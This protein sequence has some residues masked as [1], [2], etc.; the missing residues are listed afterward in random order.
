MFKRIFCLLLVLALLFP[1]LVSCGQTEEEDTVKITQ[2][3]E[4]I[5]LT[6]YGILDNL[7]TSDPDEQAKILSVKKSIEDSINTKTQNSFKTTLVY[8][9]YSTDAYEAAIEDVY[10]QFVA[11]SVAKSYVTTYVKAYESFKSDAESYLSSAAL[12]E[13]E[14]LERAAK[15]EAEKVA[16]EEEKARLD[17]IERGEEAPPEPIHGAALDILYVNNYEQYIRFVNKD[18]LVALDDYLKLDYKKITDYIHPNIL[19]AAKIKNKIYGVPMNMDVGSASY[20]LFNKTVTHALGL[21]EAVSNVKTLA[22]CDSILSAV[23]AG[24]Q[25]YILREDYP[26]L[27]N[28]V[29]MRGSVGLT[30]YDFFQDTKGFP[31]SVPNSD[32]DYYSAENVIPTYTDEAAIAHFA[33]MASYREKGYFGGNEDAPYFFSVEQLTASEI[34]AIKETDEYIILETPYAYSNADNSNTLNGFFAVST[35]SKYANRCMEIISM[36]VLNSDLINLYYYGIEGETGTYILH[37]NGTVT[38]LN[39][40]W[41]MDLHRVGNT[42]LLYPRENQSLAYKQDAIYNRKNSKDS[43]FLSFSIEYTA[44]EAAQIA[45]FAALALPYYE[46]LCSGDVSYQKTLEELNAKLEEAG[47]STFI[48][49]TLAPAFQSVAKNLIA[50]AEAQKL[51]AEEAEKQKE[52]NDESG[53]KI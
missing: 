37:D 17:R 9:W 5:Y 35:K 3:R 39:D 18:Y 53:D 34:A 14:K 43:A 30:G 48:E 23:H 1:A 36:F 15:R 20:M 33:R 44:E 46:K 42:Y 19:N 49:T 25:D 50:A 31:I 22:D 51:A 29:T 4:S 28:L 27:A 32:F 45:A 40:L 41:Q 2:T 47:L 8:N 12:R 13:K 16:E 24:K 26:I 10:A 52:N 6:F 11:E 21:E 7:D 38:V